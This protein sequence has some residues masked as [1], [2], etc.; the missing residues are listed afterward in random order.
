MNLIPNV[1]THL[2]LLVDNIEDCTV[3]RIYCIEKWE[4]DFRGITWYRLRSDSGKVLNW[5]YY[6]D[7]IEVEDASYEANLQNILSE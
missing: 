1:S 7:D 5:F 3:N 6:K 4:K 2:R